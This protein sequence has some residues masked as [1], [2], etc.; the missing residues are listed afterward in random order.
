MSGYRNTVTATRLVA[1]CPSAVFLG[2]G[3]NLLDQMKLG[4]TRP[5]LVVDVSRLPHRSIR[6]SP[7]GG[8][9]IGAAVRSSEMAADRRIHLPAPVFL[10]DNCSGPDV[11]SS[12]SATILIAGDF[13]RNFRVRHDAI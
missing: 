8:L 3:T 1:Q 7:N 5:D 10:D 6:E 12:G 2:G 4:V 9:V 13:P 11:K